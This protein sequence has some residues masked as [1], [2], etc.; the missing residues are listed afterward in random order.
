MWGV[1]SGRRSWTLASIA[2]RKTA[3]LTLTFPSMPSLISDSSCSILDSRVTRLLRFAESWK[4]G[5]GEKLRACRG[6]GGILHQSPAPIPGTNPRHQA[7]LPGRS[8]VL[9]RQAV[10][11]SRSS[12]AQAQHLLGGG[13]EE[14]EGNSG[15]RA[16][17]RARAG[18]S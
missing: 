11:A 7:H 3:A 18:F 1:E 6:W 5:G 2:C 8:P 10:A 12:H 16:P 17:L 15:H 9:G 14:A 13:R 4:G